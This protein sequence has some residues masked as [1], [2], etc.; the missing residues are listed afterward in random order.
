MTLTFNGEIYNHADLRRELQA[1]GKYEWKTDHSDTEVLLHAY[2]EWGRRFREAVLRH[3]RRRHLRRA[4][5][6]PA[7]RCT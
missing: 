2:E 6:R 7:G 3:V 1:L 5:S 4:R